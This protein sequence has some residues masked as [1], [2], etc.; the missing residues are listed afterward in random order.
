MDEV[1]EVVR[2]YDVLCNLISEKTEAHVYRHTIYLLILNRLGVKVED[3]KDDAISEFCRIS[4]GLFLEYKPELLDFNIAHLMEEIISQDK[5]ISILSNTGFIHG[6][7][8]RKV[9]V[10]YGLSDFFSFQL[11]SDEVGYSKPN[12][13]IFDLVYSSLSA[14]KA[15]SRDDIVH[16]GDNKKADFLGA[17]KA[18][19]QA[20]LI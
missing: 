6:I 14:I 16:I 10:H 8:L 9:L 3:L 1:R 2:Y 18:G 11:Y 19:F 15:V 5:T 20:V 7:A 17:T 12:R 4:E 13:E